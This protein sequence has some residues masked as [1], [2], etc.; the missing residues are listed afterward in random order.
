MVRSSFW[1]VCVTA[2]LSGGY[3]AAQGRTTSTLWAASEVLEAL[4]AIPLKS[5]PPALLRDAQGVAV[6]PNVVKAGFVA[7]ARFGHGVALV[8]L[9]DGRWSGPIFISLVGGSLGWQA[10][11]S[12]TDVVLVFKTRRGLDRVLE[13]KG[14][15]TL[16]ADAAVAAGPLGRQA[17]AGTDL[18]LRAEVYSYSRS[19]GLFVGVSLEGAGLLNNHEAN[20]AYRQRPRPEDLQAASKLCAV[21]TS[22]AGPATPVPIP[23]TVGPPQA[24]PAWVPPPPGPVALERRP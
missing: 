12:S 2:L 24:P 13:G 11:V 5:I 9:P 20:R 18:P 19:R 22:M 7:G 3:A 23:I 10:G 6:V 14:K 8:R 1:L 16:G 4:Q 15:L 21:L 17:E